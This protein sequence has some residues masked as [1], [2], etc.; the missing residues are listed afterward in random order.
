M[1]C[2]T[3]KIQIQVYA[4]LHTHPEV[5]IL[6]KETLPTHSHTHTHPRKANV[7]GTSGS[8]CSAEDSSFGAPR[9]ATR[10]ARTCSAPDSC[11]D[12]RTWRAIARRRRYVS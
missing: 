8:D 9:D 7:R 2:T 11:W 6:R 3:K 5:G 10:F 12:L 4:T 1:L